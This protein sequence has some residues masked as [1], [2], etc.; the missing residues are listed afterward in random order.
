MGN[1][2]N[3]SGLLGVFQK[4][5]SLSRGPFTSSKFLVDRGS[6][7]RVRN[8]FGLILVFQRGQRRSRGFLTSLRF[9]VDGGFVRRVRSLS[10]FKVGVYSSF[11]GHLHGHFV[12]SPLFVDGSSSGKVV[13]QVSSRHLRRRS[14][15]QKLS[16]RLLTKDPSLLRKR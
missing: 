6:V 8:S 7:E 4:R 14:A 15:R 13:V 1:V 2:R 10:R 16:L 12:S 3:P 9:F 5:I 11:P